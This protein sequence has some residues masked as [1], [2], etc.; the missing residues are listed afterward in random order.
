MAT[1]LFKHQCVKFLCAETPP[2]NIK[3]IFALSVISGGSDGAKYF[4]DVVMIATVSQI[5]GTSIVCSTVCSG[6][7]QRKHQSY[8]SLTFVRGIHRWL[9]DSPHK[10]LVPRKMFPFDDVILCS[11]FFLNDLDKMICLSC[12]VNTMSWSHLQPRYWQISPRILHAQHQN[13]FENA[14]CKTEPSLS[15]PHVLITG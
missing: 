1:I 10:G 2:G 5:T 7:D 15:L 14:V 11:I 3:D 12:I 9:V 6:A 13:E 8:A 4:S